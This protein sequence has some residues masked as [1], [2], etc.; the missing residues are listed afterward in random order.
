[1]KLS[2]NIITLKKQWDGDIFLSGS[3]TNSRG[4]AILL[5][6][7]FE[8]KILATNIDKNGNFLNIVLQLST[9]N[10][11]LITIYGPNTY[12]PGFF[13]NIQSFL[14]NDTADYN[15]MWRF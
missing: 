14:Q 5:N 4:V 3:K 1:M 6:I 8:Y 9:F 11:N 15:I 10:I 2:R 12:H 7:N 13:E